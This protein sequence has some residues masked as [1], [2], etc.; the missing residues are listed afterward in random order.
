MLEHSDRAIASNI[1]HC[2]VTIWFTGLSGAGKTTIGQAVAKELRSLGYNVTLLDGDDLRQSLC[3]DLGFS[4]AD[5][6]ENIRRIGTI[7]TDLT[8][9]GAIAIVC[10]ISPYRSQREAMRQHITH[11]IEVYVNAPLSVCEQ[12][13]VKGLYKKARAGE[14]QNFTGI[15]DPYEPPLHPDVECKTDCE[16]VVQSAAKVL[17]KVKELDYR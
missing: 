13:D 9:R 12:R 10:I 17:A 3:K 8:N 1:Q 4:K 7:A 14:I 15:D 11:F 2:G 16:S 5:R 6:E